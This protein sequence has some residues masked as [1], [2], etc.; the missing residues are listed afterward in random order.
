M[1]P[2][3]RKFVTQL[4]GPIALTPLNSI[5][6][7]LP[8]GNQRY[9]L[10]LQWLKP[11]TPLGGLG[12]VRYMFSLNDRMGALSTLATADLLLLH[13]RMNNLDAAKEAGNALVNWQRFILKNGASSIKGGLPSEFT[14][15]GQTWK[16]GDYFYASDNLLTI[17]ALLELHAATQIDRYAG[18][19]ISIS[20]WMEKTLFDGKRMGVWNVNYGPA[21][22]YMRADGALNNAIHT[23]MD[24]L[25]LRA[26]PKLHA[27][28]SRSGWNQ[29]LEKAVAFYKT[30][31]A[32]EGC[33]FDHFQPHRVNQSAGQWHWYKD[34]YLTIG[35]NTL[36]TAIA[37]QQFGL[38]D[39]V[40]AF[41]NWLKSPAKKWLW[42]YIDPKTCSPKYLATDTVYYD[43]VCTGLLRSWYNKTH[44]PDLADQCQRTLNQLQSDNGGWYWGARESDLQPLNAEQA[45][46]VGC[47][48]LADLC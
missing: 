9:E 33:W 7:N 41:S 4:I 42:G 32:T 22:Q 16:A 19:A 8:T 47:W 29:R 11:M 38:T 34:T 20:R 14:Y 25:W 12:L 26:L 48:A 44:Q 23:G 30:S 39:Q 28:D 3:R 18:T 2:S 10:F 37:A 13:L 36:R 6:Q 31:F 5:A 35:D 24:F 40:N 1:N 46:V 15:D 43:V 27:L 17:S 21:M 45:L